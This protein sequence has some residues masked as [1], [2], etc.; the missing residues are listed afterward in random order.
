MRQQIMLGP[1]IP[2][3]PHMSLI[4]RSIML[5]SERVRCLR[6]AKSPAVLNYSLNPCKVFLSA[7]KGGSPCLFF[8][9]LLEVNKVTKVCKNTANK[10]QPFFML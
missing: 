9:R 10:F 4:I 6:R 1:L 2:S 3:N 7:G 5:D 8:G